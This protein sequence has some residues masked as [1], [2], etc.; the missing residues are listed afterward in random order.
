M[1][2]MTSSPLATRLDE[3]PLRPVV[4]V[5]RETSLDHVA[6]VMRAHDVSA[7]IVGEPGE[8]V[9]IVTERD[10]AQALADGQ[11][12]SDPA[13]AIASR[14]PLTIRHRA[15][16]LEAA[17]V[18]LREGVR[19]LVVTSDHRVVGV[20]SQRDVLAAFVL[21]LAPETIVIRLDRVTIEPPEMWLG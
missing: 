20:I 13:V 18:M 10:L 12:P 7:V 17:T 2:N 6:R 1:S 19:H 15:T 3:L 14:N 21:A 11:P 5:V 4:T 8:Q 9:A 16:V